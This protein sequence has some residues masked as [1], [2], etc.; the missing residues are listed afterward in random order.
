MD[1]D[2]YSCAVSQPG[3]RTRV[4]LA[5]GWSMVHV[6]CIREALPCCCFENVSRAWGEEEATDTPVEKNLVI[7]FH[8]PR[9]L[10][11]QMSV[12]IFCVFQEASF[13]LKVARLILRKEQKVLLLG[14]IT[15]I[16]QAKTCGDCTKK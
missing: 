13:V 2:Q 14:S 10:V 16:E 15:G 11:C 12:G 4:L 9:E 3:G 7:H 6:Y 1:T 8:S 5:M